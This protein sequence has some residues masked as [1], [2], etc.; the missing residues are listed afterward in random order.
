MWQHWLIDMMFNSTHRELVNHRAS[1]ALLNLKLM[2]CKKV[3]S[4][5]PKIS[6]DYIQ[7]VTASVTTHNNNDLKDKLK[8][9]PN[10]YSCPHSHPHPWLYF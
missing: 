2:I 8:Y 1:L 6:P 4:L 3:N 5:K 10:Y 9:A 7:Y